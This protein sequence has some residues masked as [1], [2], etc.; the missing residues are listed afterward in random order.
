MVDE[1]YT[2]DHRKAKIVLDALRHVS[3][4]R[5]WHLL[6]AH[7]RTTHVHAVIQAD[8]QP[9]FVMTALKGAAS[10]LL[11]EDPDERRGRRR[12][13]RHGSTRYLFTGDAI[14]SAIRYVIDGQGEPMALYEQD[15]CALRRGVSSVGA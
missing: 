14:V 3:S 1:P 9:E 12:W 15:E 4:K 11:D 2:L 13:A 8:R 10:V 5:G 7:I 6:A